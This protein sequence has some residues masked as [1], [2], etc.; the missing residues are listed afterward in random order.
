MR[1]LVDCQNTMGSL[2]LGPKDDLGLTMMGLMLLEDEL[3]TS[4]DS[5]NKTDLAKSNNAALEELSENIF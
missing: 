1:G 2:M 3:P 5:L 4:L